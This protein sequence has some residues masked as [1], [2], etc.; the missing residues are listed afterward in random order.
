MCNG[1]WRIVWRD[2]K[3]RKWWFGQNNQKYISTNICFIHSVQ[4]G[5]YYCVH[6]HKEMCSFL[7]IYTT[8]VCVAVVYRY[9]RIN[10]V[11]GGLNYINTLL[12]NE[13]QEYLYPLIHTKYFYYLN[14][15]IDISYVMLFSNINYPYSHYNGLL[16]VICFQFTVSQSNVSFSN[17]FGQQN[18]K[19]L[20]LIS[21]IISLLYYEL[22]PSLDNKIALFH[23]H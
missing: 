2:R 18:S 6:C 17:L 4:I 9:F 3:K 12:L 22:L 15:S 19:G 23:F 8:I 13:F 14:L 7:T 21:K 11:L 5:P 16:C 1:K 20:H 10:W